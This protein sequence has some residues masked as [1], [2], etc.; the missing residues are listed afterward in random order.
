M[1]QD[2]ILYKYRDVAFPRPFRI[3]VNHRDPKGDHK[4]TQTLLST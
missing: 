1:T 3:C 2:M 4:Q